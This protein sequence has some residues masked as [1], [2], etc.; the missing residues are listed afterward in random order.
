[1]N[2]HEHYNRNLSAVTKVAYASSMSTPSDA[3]AHSEPIIRSETTDRPSQW[4]TMQKLTFRFLFVIGTGLVVLSVYGNLGLL[5]V[6]HYSKINWLLAQL[7]SYAIRGEGVDVFLSNNGDPL[8]V[9]CMHLG[10]IIVSIP[11]VIAW[12]VLD[13]NRAN[14][15]SLLGLLGVIARAA[16]ALTMIK[17]G[18]VKVLPTQMGFM[19]MPAHQLQ[20]VGDTSLFNTLWGFMGASVPYSVATGLVEVLAGVLLLWRRT[21]LPGALLAVVASAQIFLL[22]LFYDVPV[23]ILSG[24]LLIISVALTVP[25]WPNLIRVLLNRGGGEPVQYLPVAGAAHSGPRIIGLLVKHLVAVFLFVTTVASGVV[26]TYL[27]HTPRSPLDGVWRA[28]SVTVD[29][30]PASL[31]QQRPAPWSNIAIT[32]RGN[33]SNEAFAAMSKVFDSVVTQEPSGYITAWQSDR[34]GDVF[35]L[36]KQEGDDPLRVKVTLRDEV[37]R[38]ETTLDGKR[39]EGTYERRFMERDRS[40]FRL[41]QPDG[42]TGSRPEGT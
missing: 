3:E 23:K 12:T 4:T 29:G 15:R 13:R 11:I 33:D 38:L 26:M 14:Y 41:I 24:E 31:N 8:W 22:N 42:G 36:R 30:T 35:E 9:W 2:V 39:V 34:H 6:F 18:L 32:L 21:S 7:G 40:H 10:W 17:Y 5:I 20:L 37:L 19:I 28:T 1:M 16:L 25:Y 27:M